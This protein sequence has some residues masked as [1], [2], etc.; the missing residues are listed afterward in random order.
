MASK[1]VAEKLKPIVDN[2]KNNHLQKRPQD[3]RDLENWASGFC[4]S[5]EKRKKEGVPCL[6]K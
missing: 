5:I 1:L 6:K 4:L 2:Y 3:E